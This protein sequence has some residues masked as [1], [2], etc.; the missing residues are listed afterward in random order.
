MPSDV[1]ESGYG[2]WRFMNLGSSR[3]RFDERFVQFPATPQR[4]FDSAARLPSSRITLIG[5]ED[6]I[7][8]VR[9]L[10]ARGD[11]ARRHL[12]WAIE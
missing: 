6:E 2:V 9:C 10:L 7:D 8:M 1:S 5:R 12:L 4:I 11:V 3:K